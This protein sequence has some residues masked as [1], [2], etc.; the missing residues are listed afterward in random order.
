MLTQFTSEEINAT[1]QLLRV[2]INPYRFNDSSSSQGVAIT[3]SDISR[4]R[5]MELGMVVA[6]KQ[7]RASIN[8]ALEMLD[9][10]PFDE[11]INVLILDDNPSYLAILE[12]QL[13]KIKQYKINTFAKTSVEEAFEV[14]EKQEI[15]ICIS[16]YYLKNETALGLI[17]GLVKYKMNLPVIV[18]SSESTEDLTTLLLS[19]GAL[20]LIEKK[21]LTPAMLDRSLRYAIRRNQID[22]H[23]NNLISENMQKTLGQ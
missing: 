5:H 1:Q 21:D 3:F 18:I 12:E 2:S 19:Y 22:K 9:N 17:D 16:D 20:D 4:V 7:L 11:S 14:I 13:S 15:D 10:K 6:Y 23:I 8:N